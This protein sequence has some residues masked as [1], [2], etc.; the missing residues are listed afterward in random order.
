MSYYICSVCGFGTGSWLGK[1]PD[2]GEWNTLEEKTENKTTNK[3][4]V[5]LKTTKF[6]QIETKKSNRTATF[7]NEFNRVLGGGFVPGEVILLSG[8][9]GVGKS[10]ILL[11]ALQNLKT[12][13]ISGEE[14]AEQVKNRSSRLK[15]DTENYLFSDTLQVE[16]IIKGI[17]KIKD[18]IEIVV[19]DSVQTIYSA[20]IHTSYG[21][22]SQLKE[23]S[24][25]LIEFAKNINIPH[26]LIGHITKGGDIAGPKTLEHM[27]DAV[28]A[29]EGEKD[30]Q[31][32]LLRSQKNRFG[33]TDE[34]GL[35]EMNEQGLVEVDNPMIFLDESSK[36]NIPGKSFIG[37]ME[38]KR[39]LFLE[40]QVLT[41]KTFANIPRRVTKGIDYNKLLLLLAVTQ[42]HLKLHL[43]SYDVYV[44]VMGG[45]N[46][47]S[48]AADL[49]I[50][51]ALISSISNK[52]ISSD[53]LFLGEVGLLG[54]I[55]KIKSQD[56]IITEATRYHFKNI[57]SSYKLT[58]IKEIAKY[59]TSHD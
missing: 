6:N 37:F 50:I 3:K 48:P 28:L 2:C 56:K 55:R 23:S 29:F 12:L 7:L 27:V 31:F 13:Y 10:T 36:K 38:G 4:I 33:S 42:K 19:I 21:S 5:P 18:E 57:V 49:G 41:T 54:E 58:S 34:I 14:S 39:P 25:K 22:I 35:F 8:E 40:I 17:E 24:N 53:S 20:E 43:E 32:R 26:I 16:S 30:S 52:A 59:F 51:A 15:I 1:C 46:I 47:N 44:N 45:M 11:Q 9:P